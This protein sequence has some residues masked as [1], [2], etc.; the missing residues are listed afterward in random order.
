MLVLVTVRVA[1]HNSIVRILPVRII[2]EFRGFIDALG[3]F[4]E[5]LVGR[6]ARTSWRL[7]GHL[8][9][10]VCGRAQAPAAPRIL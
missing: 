10:D 3:D 5:L 4:W 2:C 7:H 1:G 8:L 6:Q 9:L